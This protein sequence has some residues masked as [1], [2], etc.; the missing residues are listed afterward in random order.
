MADQVQCSLYQIVDFVFAVLGEV[1]E[2]NNLQEDKDWYQYWR[3]L[4]AK[5]SVSDI[6]EFEKK[7]KGTVSARIHLEL[8]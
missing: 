7:Y 2:E 8:M 4:F 3:L 1:D 5:I 6:K